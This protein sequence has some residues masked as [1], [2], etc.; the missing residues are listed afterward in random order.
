MVRKRTQAEKRKLGGIRKLEPGDQIPALL[1][2]EPHVPFLREGRGAIYF[3]AHQ[4]N[5]GQLIFKWGE[6]TCVPRRQL[7]YRAC[8]VDG[9]IQMWFVAFE[10]KRRLIAERIIHLRLREKGYER[11]R[12]NEP[13]SCGHR[14]R[15]YYFMLPDGSLED[16]EKIAQECLV[17]IGEREVVR[18]TLSWVS[19]LMWYIRGIAWI[20]T[21]L[22][23]PREKKKRK[24]TQ[25]QRQLT[26]PQG[27]RSRNQASALE[28]DV[29]VG[30]PRAKR[31]L[32]D[33]EKEKADA[34]PEAADEPAG[35]QKQEPSQRVRIRRRHRSAEGQEKATR[36][37]TNLVPPREEKEDNADAALE[38]ADEPAVNQILKRPP[39]SAPD[40]HHPPRTVLLSTPQHPRNALLHWQHPR[41][42]SLEEPIRRRQ[43]TPAPFR[44]GGASRETL[45]DVGVDERQ[46]RSGFSGGWC[47]LKGCRRGES[48]L[49]DANVDEMV[50]PRS[51]ATSPKTQ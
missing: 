21:N 14:H 3:T 45:V 13:C 35:H 11:V 34:A 27:T 40:D 25:R 6:S 46:I 51:T 20:L 31:K 47:R 43:H 16:F 42:R 50:K 4:Q 12:F 5:D 1:A 48:N 32:Y 38:A 33:A 30:Q 2:L 22:V 17:E 28:Y 7:D 29:G 26:N 19:D 8:E 36:R 23:P 18:N 44:D 24:Q 39:Q 41:D 15:E 49:I 9:G 10:V 37:L